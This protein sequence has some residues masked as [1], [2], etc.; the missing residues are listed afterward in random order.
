MQVSSN[1]WPFQQ[2]NLVSTKIIRI[3]KIDSK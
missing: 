1:Y 3:F 2:N